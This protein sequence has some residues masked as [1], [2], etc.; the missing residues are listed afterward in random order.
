MKRII[1]FAI[2][3]I[4]FFVILQLISSIYTLWHKQDVLTNAQK[5]LQQEKQEN[6][7]LK[8]QL[9]QVNSPEF[10]EKEARD[11]LLMVKPGES[12]VLIDQNLLKAS[13][14]ASRNEEEKTYW[15]QWFEIF[16][17]K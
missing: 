5:Q 15:Q 4:L 9:V 10:V 6:T 11:K 17:G 1:F 8:Q 12:E 13:E 3:L 14:S 16:F 2:I 7:K